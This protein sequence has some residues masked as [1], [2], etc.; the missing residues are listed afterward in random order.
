MSTSTGADI[1]ELANLF[2]LLE[3]PDFEALKADIATYGLREPIWTYQGKV[4]DGRNR[5]R[6]CRELGID[7]PTREWDGKGSLVAFALSLNLHRRHLTSSQRAAVAVE[8]L[9]FLE[10]EAKERQR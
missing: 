2:P 4:I 6:A 7:P 3:G 8:V 5:L 9:P 10:A 1:H